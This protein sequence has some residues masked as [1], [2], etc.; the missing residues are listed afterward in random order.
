MKRLFTLLTFALFI[1]LAKAQFQSAPAFP[2]AEGFGRYTTG[3]RGG[4]IYHVTNLNDY[5]DDNKYGE[6]VADSSA[7]AQGTLRYA[8]RKSG[9]RIIVFDVAGTIDLVCPLRIRQDSVTILGQTAPGDGICLKNYTLSIHA[10][11][12]IVR[13]IRCRMGDELKTEDDAMNAAHRDSTGTSSSTTVLFPGQ[14]TN[15]VHSMAIRTSP[16]SGA[17]LPSH[18]ECLFTIKASMAMLASGVVKASHSITTS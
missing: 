5:C 9:A 15:A 17:S 7:E 12:V 18:S 16:Y 10:D 11:N 3:G 2:G 1:I 4:K 13:Y 8:I 14:P 6:K